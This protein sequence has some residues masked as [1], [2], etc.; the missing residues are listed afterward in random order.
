MELVSW[1]DSIPNQMESNSKFH[2]SS[3]HQADSITIVSYTI[4]IIV[5]YINQLS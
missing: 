2:G 4:L 3:H 1:D 5:I